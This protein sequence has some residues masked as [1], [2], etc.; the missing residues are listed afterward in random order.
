MANLMGLSM[1]WHRDN[2]PNVDHYYPHDSDFMMALREKNTA[3][4]K[5][6]P[7]PG[8]APFEVTILPQFRTYLGEGSH[9]N[10]AG[11]GGDAALR[12]ASEWQFVVNVSGCKLLGLTNLTGD[13]LSYLAGVRKSFAASSR[14]SGHTQLLIGGTKL[15]QEYVDHQKEEVLN[16]E[17]AQDGGPNPLH[18]A[19]SQHWETNGF[20]VQVGGGVDVKLNKALSL[21]MVDFGFS[22][23][24]SNELN[25]SNYQQTLQLTS[26]LTLRMGTW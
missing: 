26:G 7:P 10:C 13:S 23:S 14:W 3:P 20:T 11:G 15:T 4:V 1:P 5:V 18:S 6:S 21:R 9:G 12:L 16:A 19:Y 24:W 17:A 8:V 25:G 22:R 2:R